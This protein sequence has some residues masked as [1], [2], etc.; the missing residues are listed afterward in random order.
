MV[1]LEETIQF[2][3]RFFP[4]NIG[5]RELKIFPISSEMSSESSLDLS[6][7]SP[8]EFNNRPMLAPHWHFCC[9]GPCHFHT[10]DLPQTCPQS[11]LWK[12]KVFFGN[13]QTPS[14]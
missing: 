10:Q 5:P 3:E 8:L 11:L 12:L 1:E 9:G 13:P 7:A 6:L 2:I 4:L 14:P